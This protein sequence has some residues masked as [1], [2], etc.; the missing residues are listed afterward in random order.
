MRRSI[1]DGEIRFLVFAAFVMICLGCPV[2]IY[3][4]AE[5]FGNDPLPDDHLYHDLPSIAVD[6]LFWIEAC[7]TSSLM[8]SARKWWWLVAL[9]ALPLLV[10]TG[11]LAVTG[12]MWIDG[13]Y[14]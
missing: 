3:L 7:A 4:L 6:A 14:L 11:V 10:L 13:T 1:S 2:A 9:V 12:G 8:I 5:R